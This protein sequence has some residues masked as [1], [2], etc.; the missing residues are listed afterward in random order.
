MIVVTNN[1]SKQIIQPTRFPDGTSQVW[2]LNIAAFQKAPVKI[3]WHFEEEAELIWV[4]QLSTLLQAEG[5]AIQELYMPYL[6][7]A[8]QD[9]AVSNNSTFAK[10]VFIDMLFKAGIGK[11]SALDAHSAHAQV[12]SYSAKPYI[13]QAIENFKPEVLVFPDAGAFNRYGQMLDEYNLAVLVLD[14]DRDQATGEIKAL[15]IDVALSTANLVRQTTEKPLKMLMVDDICDGGAT[16]I[17]AAKYL[18]SQYSNGCTLG[19]YVTHGIFSKG[20]EGL[21]KAGISEFFTTQSLTKN[22]AAYPLMEIE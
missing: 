16:F 21:M 3:V 7:Y 6:P 14:K 20:F 12:F 19:L 11:I 17:N 18:C 9:K 4:N 5:L 8:R 13:A 2:K 1:N 10:T 22:I 15:T